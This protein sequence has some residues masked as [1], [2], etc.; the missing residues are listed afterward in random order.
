M[1]EHEPMARNV[2]SPHVVTQQHTIA[3]LLLSMEAQLQQAGLGCQQFLNEGRRQPRVDLVYDL[4]D[5]AVKMTSKAK[6]TKV[7]QFGREE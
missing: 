5:H 3:H 1:L 7:L 2:T 6:Q 4:K